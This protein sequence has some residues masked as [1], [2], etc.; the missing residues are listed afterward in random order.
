MKVIFEIEDNPHELA[1]ADKLTQKEQEEIITDSLSEGF[2]VDK[3]FIKIIKI[4]V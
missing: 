2:N 1:Q 3:E 4:E